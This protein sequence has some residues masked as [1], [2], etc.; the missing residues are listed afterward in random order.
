[1]VEFGTTSN[2]GSRFSDAAPVTEHL[3]TLSNLLGG[4][5]YSYRVSSATTAGL[6]RSEVEN[7]STFKPSGPIQFV[8]L[9]DSGQGTSAQF[10]IAEVIR[11]QNPD[12]VLHCGDLVY[13][14]INDRSVDWR[15]FNYYQ[16]HMASTPYFMVVGNHDLNCCLGDGE[17][18]YNPTNWVFNATNFQNSFFLPTNPVTG[19]KHFYSFD[20]GDAHF[21]ALYNPWFADYVFRSGSDQFQWLTNDLAQSGKPWKFI[22]MHM[23]LATSG[24]H[25]GRDDNANF[26]NDSS[27][28]MNLLLPVAARYGVQLIMGGHDHNYE[29]FAPTNGVH[30]FVTGGGGGAVYGMKQR[31]PASVQ[32]WATNHCTKVSVSGDTALIEALDLRGAVFDSFVIQQTAAPDQLFESTWH[33]PR[34]PAGSANDGDGNILGQRFDFAGK[35]LLARAGRSSNLGRVY[36]NNDNSDL[37][38]G[39]ESVMIYDDQTVYLFIES[40]RQPGVTNLAG[41]GNGI[42]D[43]RREGADGLDFLENVGFTNFHPSIGCILGDEYGDGQ[44]RNFK[45]AAA[46][47]NTGQGIFRLDGPLNNVAGTRLQQFNRSPQI[48]VMPDESNADLIEIAIPFKALGN[49]RPGEVVK[50]GAIVAGGDFNPEAQT[51]AVDTGFLG[52]SLSGEGHGPIVL[53]AVRVRLAAN[54]K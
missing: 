33:S 9:G 35:P 41:L 24:G 3:C 53:G 31:H 34:L 5:K 27:E 30:H 47:L 10:A 18:D 46:R 42:I 1:M 2:L 26:I 49:I 45:R 11:R 52:L 29:R 14:G 13:Q 54:P 43:P 38:I 8:A 51:Q 50:L 21:V 39:F 37:Y 36:V 22:F 20:A 16:G 4:Q 12:L 25:F 32:F 40:S 23:P 28:L 6:I 15:F 17:P 7:F 48:D 44:F 19:T